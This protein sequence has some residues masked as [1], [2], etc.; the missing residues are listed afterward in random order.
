MSPSR[1]C[2]CTAIAAAIGLATV[3]AGFPA[4]ADTVQVTFQNHNPWTQEIGSVDRY[5]SSHDY[6]V[7]VD[8]DKTL[9]INLV[10]RDPNVFFTIRN[11]TEGK[12]LV[13]TYQ[14]G[15]TTWSTQNATASTY[16]IH[17]YVQPEAMQRGET[18]K[19]AL[20]IGQYGA[21]DM[22]PATTTVTFQDNNPWAQEVSDVESSAT[23]HDY[24]V[25][26]EA[27]KTLQVNLLTQNPQVHFKVKDQAGQELVDSSKTGTKTWSMPVATAT[28]FTIEVYAD[29]A[30]VPPGKKVRYALQIG[31]YASGARPAGPA[32]AGAPAATS[33][34]P[35]A[36][37]PASGTTAAPV[38]A[39]ATTSRR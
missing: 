8:A 26:I 13:D 30:A 27:G 12:Q 24:T 23:A 21:Q 5:N 9:Q 38:P 36:M 2:L 3:G 10:T 16:T 39:P 34:S 19:Y 29:P 6:T 33:T 4:F 17:V 32:T 18:A 7:A 28:D 31:H 15:A 20:Q 22:Q 1:L 37:T 11:D 25:A 35:N 14:T